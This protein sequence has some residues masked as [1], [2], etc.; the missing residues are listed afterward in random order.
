MKIFI[1]WSGTRSQHLAQEL[2]EWLPLVLHYVEPWMSEQDIQAGDRWAQ[3]VA[4]ELSTSN[5]GI[6]CVTPDN[7][8]SPWLLF[9]AG[10]LAKSLDTGRVIPLLLDL[11]L[12]QLTGPLAQFQAKKLSRNGMAEIINTIQSVSDDSIPDE[13]CKALVELSWGNFES[14]IDE[15]AGEP[16]PHRQVRTEA[17]ILEELVA[18]IRGLDTRVREAEEI[19][20]ASSSRAPDLRPGAHP[21]ATYELA[22][23]TLDTADP[24]RL[25]ICASP[26]R[27]APW[28]VELAVDLYQAIENEHPLTYQKFERLEE[29]LGLIDSNGSYFSEVL[30]I[31]PQ[32][33]EVLRR[34][35]TMLR[36]RYTVNASRRS[37]RAST[38]VPDGV[39][40]GRATPRRVT[41]PRPTQRK[42]R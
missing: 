1:S 19:M 27:N 18:S 3:S 15:I 10:A 37:E 41:A 2:R 31:N 16:S 30:G 21:A 29:L 20:L 42:L 36:E 39:D 13:R 34:Q 22:D 26:L 28:I 23:M 5:F 32:G 7:Q 11:D 4:G 40:P 24:A 33:V 6:V 17:E 9:E 38:V 25:L 12:A 8:N 35:T 14:K